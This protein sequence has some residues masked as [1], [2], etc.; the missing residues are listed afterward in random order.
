MKIG[1]NRIEA[2]GSFRK[3]LGTIETLMHPQESI[4][5]KNA[6]MISHQ[7][8]NGK[9]IWQIAFNAKDANK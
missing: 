3:S 5:R 6:A 8:K 2:Y 9:Q 4:P 7:M 1:K